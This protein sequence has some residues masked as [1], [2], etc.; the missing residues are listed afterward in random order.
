MS[1]CL[2]HYV[3]LYL[4]MLWTKKDGTSMIISSLEDVCISN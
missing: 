4:T 1:N 3:F 2:D